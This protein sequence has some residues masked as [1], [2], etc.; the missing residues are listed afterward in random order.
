M[1]GERHNPW[2]ERGEKRD[3]F[4][5]LCLIGRWCRSNCRGYHCCFL[6]P[7]PALET[8]QRAQIGF[9]FPPTTKPAKARYCNG[10]ALG[11]IYDRHP[12][13]PTQVSFHYSW[14]H[15]ANLLGQLTIALRTPFVGPQRPLGTTICNR[16]IY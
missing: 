15:T 11:Y 16:T 13:C 9:S 10:K 1:Y 14:V 8:C 4:F 6:A 2:I 3:Y 5:S 7:S 12:I